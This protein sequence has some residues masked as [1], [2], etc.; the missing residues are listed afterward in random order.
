MMIYDNIKKILFVLP[1]ETAHNFVEFLLRVF[2]IFR[3][4]KNF[5]ASRYFVDDE[6]LCQNIFNQQFKNPIGLAAGF[7]KDAT[8][9]GG[10]YMLGFGYSEVGTVTKVA[11]IGNEKPRL[12]RIKSRNSLQNAMGFNNK[13]ADNMLNNIAKT[14]ADIPIGISIGKNKTTPNSDTIEE[15]LYL[16]KKF[17]NSCDYIAINISSPNTPN[18]RDLQNEAFVAEL[19]AKA[20]NITAK[21]ILLKLSCDIDKT[22]AIDICQTAIKHGCSG[23]I[24]TNT[25]IDYSLTSLSKDLGGLS[26]EVI[27]DKAYEL[28]ETIAKE[29]YGK[30]LLVSVGGI[31][32]AD[33]VY[34]RIKAGAGLVQIYTGLIYKGPQMCR[35]I[36][37][38]LIRLLKADGYCNISQAI[39]VDR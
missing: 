21:P 38:E 37:R 23:I 34:K 20:T 36:N 33:D 35:H 6:A 18:L 12:F 13:G 15:Y 2:A 9:I 28:F 10:A 8:M 30:T 27:K 16:V 17:K 24:A 4:S 7:D 39:G 22:I 29:F 25:S 11:Q 3:L 31:S 32:S 5:F 14:T 26:G 19:F 1:P